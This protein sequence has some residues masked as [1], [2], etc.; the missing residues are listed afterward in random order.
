MAEND[1]LQSWRDLYQFAVSSYFVD[2]S[3]EELEPGIGFYLKYRCETA[4]L[5]GGGF[6]DREGFD[7]SIGPQLKD[8][9]KLYAIEVPTYQGSKV[10]N[11]SVATDSCRD[12]GGFNAFQIRGLFDSGLNVGVAVFSDS[13][14]WAL[15]K[16]PDIVYFFVKT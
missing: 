9:T 1:S 8:G 4:M 13:K 10:T 6:L 16:D 2:P 14:R 11:C 5:S 3:S 7:A 12:W 15:V